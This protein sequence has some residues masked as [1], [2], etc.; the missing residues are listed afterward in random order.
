[1]LNQQRKTLVDAHRSITRTPTKN[2]ASDVRQRLTKTSQLAQKLTGAQRGQQ[3]LSTARTD[4]I[5]AQ[6]EVKQAQS[7][8]AA[9]HKMERQGLGDYWL[10]D[11]DTGLKARDMD[12]EDILDSLATR[13]FFDKDEL[14]GRGPGSGPSSGYTGPRLPTPPPPAPSAFRTIIKKVASGVTSTIRRV[15]GGDPTIHRRTK[16]L[17]HDGNTQ[18]PGHGSSHA[19][20]ND[21]GDLLLPGAT[22]V[23]QNQQGRRN[24]GPT[25]TRREQQDLAARTDNTKARNAFNVAEGDLSTSHKMKQ[26]G[27]SAYGPGNTGA[28]LKARDLDNVEELMEIIAR[29]YYGANEEY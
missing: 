14:F 21:N 12:V 16:P 27:L 18:N 24:V 25:G 8:L 23:Q 5:S 4:Y 2:T 26:G 6:K 10:G 15:R 9:S 7:N 17:S 13:G 22:S 28:G 20:Y 19:V 3:D 29:G 1:M 11:P